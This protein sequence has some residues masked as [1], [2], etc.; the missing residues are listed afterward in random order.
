MKRRKKKRKVLLFFILLIV[1]IVF[2][3]II[4]LINKKKDKV[5]VKLKDNLDVLVNSNVKVSDFITD[6]SNGKLKDNDLVID[7]SNIGN[8]VVEVVIIN[9]NNKEVNYKFN[10]NVI[11]NE[12]PIINS[13]DKITIYTNDEVDLLDYVTVSDNYDNDVKVKVEGS[14]DNTKGGEYKLSYVATDSS[15]NETVKEFTLVVEQPKYKKMPDKTIK[16]SKGYTLKIKNGVA[17]V[18]GVLIANKTYYLPENYKPTDSYNSNITDNCTTC[19]NKDVMSAFNEMKSDISSLGMSL[20]IVSGYRSYN[21]QKYLYNSYVNRDGKDAADTYSARAGFSEHQTGLCFDV[22]YAGS[23]FDSTPE[24]KWIHDNAYLYGFIL[25]YP[26]GKED[27]T[28]Y[29]YESWHLR[30]VGKDLAKKLYND[31]DWV[32]LEEYFGITS[33]YED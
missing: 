31:G 7:T 2:S 19:I 33:K 16:T 26:K 29:M 4:I 3:F 15:N 8:K 1:V 13:D 30:Y 27:I 24:A 12:K 28:G 23:A 20:R 14:Y 10:I 25:R 9:N 21:T 6:I 17:Y 11:D 5:D 32:T 18:D 22:N